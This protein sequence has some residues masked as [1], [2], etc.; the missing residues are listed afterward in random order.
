MGVIFS[1]VTQSYY[2]ERST[3]GQAI[4]IHKAP[5][6]SAAGFL[7]NATVTNFDAIRGEITVRLTFSYYGADIV[8]DDEFSI[9]EDF[10][11]ITNTIKGKNNDLFKANNSIPPQ[12]IVLST[13]GLFSDYPFD[14]HTADLQLQM[15]NAK[16]ETYDVAL[17]VTSAVAGFNITATEAKGPQ[18]TM[19]QASLIVNRTPTVRK[20]SIFINAT[21][22][23]LAMVILGVAMQVLVGGRKP[24]IAM[25]TFMAGM[26]FAFPA[27]RNLQP[28]IPP[29][30][31][32][33]DYYAT[34][35]AQGIAAL[36]ILTV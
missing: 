4:E 35:F 23:I 34:F 36:G 2:A 19:T 27:V 33:T 16:N 5:E 3:L 18:P 20:F 6:D 30:G 26:M 17:N 24:E 9:R 28:G 21:M 14:V 1:R 29:L 15:G 10:W 7:C 25:L 22:W 13:A 11:L 31:S 8:A 32:I 12:E